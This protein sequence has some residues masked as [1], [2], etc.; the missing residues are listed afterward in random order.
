MHSMS[1]NPREVMWYM[2]AH[3]AVSLSQDQNKLLID[4][5]CCLLI[6]Q[7]SYLWGS[8]NWLRTLALPSSSSSAR[9]LVPAVPG[10]S[11]PCLG[12]GCSSAFWLFNLSW[13][14]P[15]LKALK[16]EC[17]HEP[18]TSLWI[19]PVHTHRVRISHTEKLQQSPD[20]LPL[21]VPSLPSYPLFL[22]LPLL[23]AWPYLCSWGSVLLPIHQCGTCYQVTWLTT[24]VLQPYFSKQPSC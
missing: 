19:C 15:V 2:E 18:G 14:T 12:G 20:F 5:W 6:A 3:I 9:S 23:P 17:G 4:S 8:W 22:S 1:S 24:M 13:A 7:L 11:W 10:R 16:Q 21:P